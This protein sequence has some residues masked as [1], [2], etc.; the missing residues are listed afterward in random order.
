[1]HDRTE[2]YLITISIL[3]SVPMALLF[4]SQLLLFTYPQG[5]G[6]LLVVKD[7]TAVFNKIEKGQLEESTFELTFDNYTRAKNLQSNKGECFNYVDT[8]RSNNWLHSRV[9]SLEKI[10]CPY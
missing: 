6:R 3:F 2:K 4:A 7:K 9:L 1:M 5:E 10:S 8:R